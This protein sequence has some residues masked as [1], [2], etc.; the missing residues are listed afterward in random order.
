MSDKVENCDI[1]DSESVNEDYTGVEDDGNNKF[2]GGDWEW[3][4]WN[5][6][7]EDDDVSGPPMNYNYNE[8]YGSTKSFSESFDTIIQCVFKCTA[9][10]C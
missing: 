4:Q 10:I 1:R 9:I 3:V 2:L 6:I 7:G 8:I 5:T